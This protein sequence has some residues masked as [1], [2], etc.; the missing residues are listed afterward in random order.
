MIRMTSGRRTLVVH[1]PNGVGHS[2]QDY[3][4]CQAK[5]QPAWFPVLNAGLNRYIQGIEE[6]RAGFL[7]ADA[8]L[9]PV[10]EV[11]G[12]VPLESQTVHKVIVIIYL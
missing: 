5:G 6:Y 2:E 8:V 12:L 1:F 11:L 4:I 10:G 7:K 3:P 9:A